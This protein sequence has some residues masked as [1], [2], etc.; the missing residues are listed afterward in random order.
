MSERPFLLPPWSLTLPPSASTVRSQ[1]TC[2]EESLFNNFEVSGRKVEVSS[3]RSGQSFAVV[4]DFHLPIRLTDVCIPTN[5]LLS[6]VSV[7]VWLA[8]G[9][10]PLRVLHAKDLSSKSVSLGN[11]SPSPLCQFAKVSVVV[12]CVS[13]TLL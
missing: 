8:D 13:C 1:M 3:A 10:T 6:S 7:D 5:P 9:E 2:L 11:L 12:V 4:L